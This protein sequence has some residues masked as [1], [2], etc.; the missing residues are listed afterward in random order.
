MA[1][2]NP[3]HKFE[4]GN[5]HGGRS[6]K[7]KELQAFCQEKSTDVLNKLFEMLNS[8]KT[9]Y[10]VQF[11]IAKLILAYGFGNPTDSLVK[12]KEHN[13]NIERES[14]NLETCTTAVKEYF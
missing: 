12:I 13:D 3:A 2:A 4:A 8:D 10:K 11:D 14:M 6:P 5:T 9:P 7:V 1:N